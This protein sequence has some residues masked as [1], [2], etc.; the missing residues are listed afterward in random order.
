MVVPT[1]SPQSREQ[2]DRDGTT[3]R[4]IPRP[5]V[6]LRAAAAV[7]TGFALYEASP[8]R[9]LW[10]LA[11]IALA[12]L[13]ALV[14]DR[15]ARAGFGYGLLFG[16]AYLLPLFGWLL[17][18]M[19][20]QFGPWPWL[21][22]SLVEA[23]FFGL[24]GAGMAR[25]SRLPL[26]PVWMAAVFLA[27]EMLRSTVPFGGF[28][29]GRLAFTQATGPL[30]PLAAVGGAG[31]VTFAAAVIGAALAEVVRRLR[32][33]RTLIVPAA[34]GLVPALLALAVTPLV[35]VDPNAGSARV[36]V[37]QGNAPNVGLD[38]LY[39]DDV[40]HENHRRAALK[41][42]DDVRA[43]RVPR[44]DVVVLPEQVGSWGP[45]RSDPDLDEV[46]S[47]LGVPVVA[48]GVSRDRDGQLRNRLIRWD[49][50]AGPTAE[51]AKW[52]LVP[53]GEWFPARPLARLVTP[54][55]DKFTQDMVPGDQPGVFATGPAR[56]GVGLC[57]DVAYDD[58]Y[59]AA[60]RAGATL[61]AVPTNNAWYGLSEMSYQQ[62]AMSQLRAVENGRAM[63]VSATSGVSAV[64]Q[65]DGTI[66]EQSRQFTAQTLIAQVP[67][68][69]T[70]T[71]AT[72]LGVIPSWVLAALGLAA[73]AFTWRRPRHWG[74][75]QRNLAYNEPV[76]RGSAPE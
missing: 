1:V 39:L 2:S 7:V 3:R 59:T 18:F 74:D 52:H 29:F 31:L 9:G 45:S 14:R 56:L 75:A 54:F 53:Y 24:A 37:V 19:G 55:A 27:A 49:P 22:V 42:V 35:G 34:V 63:L 60:T 46:T 21:A 13:T 30:L 40:L 72:R 58:V 36:A 67:L 48:G 17:D 66:S 4:W 41:L 16:V 8:P 51:F 73:L 57:Y 62:L 71:L 20:V 43:G 26:A 6:L 33:P 64:V 68:R 10:W 12:G 23:L 50:V 65:P 47:Q 25:V 44:P 32:S 5:A 69:S 61:L 11:L 28:P 38:L 76:V 70:L 15:S